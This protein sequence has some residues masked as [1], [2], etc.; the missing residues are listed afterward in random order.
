MMPMDIEYLLRE[1]GAVGLGLFCFVAGTIVP[2]SSEAAL[3]LALAGG[4]SPLVALI[5][6]S[7]GNCLACTV[8]YGIG[9]WFRVHM[10]QK[11]Q[12]TRIGTTAL[13]WI[14]CTRWWSLSASWLPFIGDPLTIAAGIAE[15][16]IARFIGIVWS[17]RILRYGVVLWGF[18]LW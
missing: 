7:C 18:S 1:F 15:V 4:M 2:I 6:A 11:L 9:Y 16:P 12:A 3:A 13:R 5:S 17:L 14:D 8:N 10:E